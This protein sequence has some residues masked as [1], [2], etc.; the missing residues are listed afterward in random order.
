[1]CSG[2]GTIGIGNATPG[3]T[4]TIEAANDSSISLTN[5]AAKYTDINVAG[6]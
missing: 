4:I 5:T 3:G 2:S 1:M 6:S